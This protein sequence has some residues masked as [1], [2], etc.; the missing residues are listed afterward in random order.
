MYLLKK[1]VWKT[2]QYFPTWGHMIGGS[3]HVAEILNRHRFQT[4]FFK[5]TFF[6]DMLLFFKDT[7]L[8]YFFLKILF[9]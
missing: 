2:I 7:F 8:K 5:E 9:S 1:C 3:P 4:I 6:K